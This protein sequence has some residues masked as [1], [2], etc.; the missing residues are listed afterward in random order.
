MPRF[1]LLA[2][3]LVSFVGPALIAANAAPVD[4]AGAS[5]CQT[6]GFSIDADPKGTNLRGAPRA[7][8][9]IIGHL[10]P[11]TKIDRDTYT[12]VEFEIVGSKDGWLL[13]RN[14]KPETDFRLNAANAA[15]G[16]GWVSGK[17]VG[18]TLASRPLRAAPR[19]DAAIVAQ[20]AGSNWGPDSVAVLVV[21]ACQGGYVEITGTPVGDKPLRGW[22]RSP[23]AAQ[24]TTCDRSD[25]ND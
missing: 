4:T 24:L 22:S 12:G 21:H 10:A 16:R 2:T 13:I 14:G 1:C 3:L 20:F 23:C 7:D 5:Q 19:R 9:P 8:A 25:Q 17:L 6:R 15:D 18:V 11:L